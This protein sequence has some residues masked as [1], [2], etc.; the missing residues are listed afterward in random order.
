MDSFIKID[1][2]NIT[3]EQKRKIEFEGLVKNKWSQKIY[4]IIILASNTMNIGVLAY[5]KVI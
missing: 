1:G 5:P 4:H 3:F 2:E